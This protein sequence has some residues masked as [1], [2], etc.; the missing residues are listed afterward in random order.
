MDMKYL[1]LNMLKV[2]AHDLNVGKKQQHLR[3]ELCSRET[4]KICSYSW[5]NSPQGIAVETKE[6][7]TNNKIKI[8][9]WCQELQWSCNR[10]SLPLLAPRSKLTDLEVSDLNAERQ[11]WDLWFVMSLWKA[12]LYNKFPQ[13]H[14]ISCLKKVTSR[15]FSWLELLYSATK[16]FLNIPIH[17][18]TSSYSF[19]L[20]DLQVLPES[21]WMDML[22]PKIYMQKWVLN[23]DWN[24]IAWIIWLNYNSILRPS[25]TG[26][27]S[28]N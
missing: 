11:C 12:E 1:G 8:W 28:L 5:K 27:M 21:W 16:E 10:Q 6:S 15:L 4:G 2:N 24:I 14:Q 22:C 7:L 3:A 9:W 26:T 18:S 25:A 20:T 23:Y 19:I 17:P 13:A